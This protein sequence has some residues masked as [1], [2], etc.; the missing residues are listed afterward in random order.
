MENW[1]SHQ[2]LPETGFFYNSTSYLY[3]DCRTLELLDAKRLEE[4]RDGVEEGR[5]LFFFKL[6][7]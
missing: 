7:N 2:L 5:G 4:G 6:N 1:A 3:R